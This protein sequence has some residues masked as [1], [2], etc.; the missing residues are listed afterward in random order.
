MYGSCATQLDLPSSDLDVVVRGLDRPSDTVRPLGKNGKPED[1]SGPM[2]ERMP[3]NSATTAAHPAAMQ[4]HPQNQMASQQPMHPQMMYGHLSLNADRIR[5]LAMELERQ[6]WA[7]HVK[8]I[9]TATVPVIKVLADPSRTSGNGE[10]LMQ[11]PMSTESSPINGQSISE[12]RESNGPS[13]NSMPHFQR[14]QTP[15]WR[16]ADVM[17]GLLKVDITFEGPE[18]G[19]IGSTEFS[20]RVVKE[21]CDETSLPPDST[22]AVQV[23]MVVKELLAQRRLNEPFS[24]GLS[25]YALLLLVISVLRERAIIREELEKVEHQRRIVAAGNVDSGLAAFPSGRETLSGEEVENMLGSTSKVTNDGSVEKKKGNTSVSVVEKRIAKGSSGKP[26]SEQVVRAVSSVK[27]NWK[28]EDSSEKPGATMGTVLAGTAS[29]S[30]SNAKTTTSS[31]ASIAKKSSSAVPPSKPSQESPR[32]TPAEKGS[33]QQAR[34]LRK[35]SSFADAVANGNQGG[36]K[37]SINSVPTMSRTNVDEAQEKKRYADPAASKKAISNTKSTA[38]STTS[39]SGT[40]STSHPEVHAPT[41]AS[42]GSMFPQGFHD[43]TEVLCSGETTAGKLLM[44]FLLFYGQHFDSQSTAIDYSGTHRRDASGN[45]GYSQS[46]P[47]M[48]RRTAGSYDPITGMLTV[49]PIVVYDPLEGAEA[50]NVAR[51]C[52]AWSSIRWVFAQSYLTLLSTV[53]INQNHSSGQV[54]RGVA[55]RNEGKS[56]TT[57]EKKSDLSHPWSGP[58]GH[59]KSGNMMIDPSSPLLE[60]LLSF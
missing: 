43:V 37:Q 18:H 14:Q 35:A 6:P 29:W 49:D 54:M 12:Q 31:W 53:E 26:E 39:P 23:L 28:E 38:R 22:P 27:Q 44:H 19:G 20:S 17:N 58:Y 59:D 30:S 9:P 52:F 41:V 1:A 21:F 4:Q 55:T 51:S 32:S 3:E 5:C 8:A 36:L 57:N 46:S 15:P 10:W 2:G 25:S 13:E 33:Q 34:T 47:Y 24:G 42:N 11:P 16:G 60:L 45:N 56:C 40:D 50:N 7:A 48:L